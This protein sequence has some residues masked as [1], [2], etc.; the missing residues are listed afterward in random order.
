MLDQINVFSIVVLQIKQLMLFI[1]SMLILSD[2][3]LTF[4]IEQLRDLNVLR[5][6]RKLCIIRLYGRAHEKK[7]FPDPWHDKFKVENHPE[8]EDIDSHYL[9]ELSESELHLDKL[10]QQ[11]KLEMKLEYKDLL[12]KDKDI[13]ISI[14]QE[15]MGLEYADFIEN[16]G[17]ATIS[18]QDG[19]Y[20]KEYSF[21]HDLFKKT[22]SGERT[23][24]DD[25]DGHWLPKLIEDALHHKIQCNP[26]IKKMRLEYKGLCDKNTIPS[27]TEQNR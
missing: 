26:E 10:M 23:K 16:E 2:K 14:Q 13:P 25:I 17:I 1:V 3:F 5:K 11:E 15:E 7:D 21:S 19:S 8:D 4:Y 12:E 18:F 9:P 27:S 20:E 24:Q 6:R 22:I